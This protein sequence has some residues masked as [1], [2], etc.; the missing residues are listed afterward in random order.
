MELPRRDTRLGAQWAL[1]TDV[2]FVDNSLIRASGDLVSLHTRSGVGPLAVTPLPPL[3]SCSWL[4]RILSS[5]S[6]QLEAEM[7]RTKQTARYSSGY[8]AG[9]VHAAFEEMG[10]TPQDV[11]E[12]RS[13]YDQG[14]LSAT[15]FI[16]MLLEE[17]EDK[18]TMMEGIQSNYS[19]IVSAAEEEGWVNPYETGELDEADGEAG[20]AATFE[21]EANMPSVV[22]LLNEQASSSKKDVE[23]GDTK[24]KRRK[25]RNQ[26]QGDAD[27][28]SIE[29]GAS[30]LELDPYSQRS[31]ASSFR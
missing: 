11:A 12:M 14:E 31:E 17:A 8:P 22:D 30:L 7:A 2:T 1:N 3:L 23:E 28:D 18:A 16:Q 26:L 15:E 20:A 24:R 4:K 10:Y 9:S 25:N 21:D 29:A 5:P 19:D 6:L 27:V 13:E